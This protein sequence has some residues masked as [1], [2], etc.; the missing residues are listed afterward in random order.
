MI[1]GSGSIPFPSDFISIP[2]FHSIPFLPFHSSFLLPFHPSRPVHLFHSIILHSIHQTKTHFCVNSGLVCRSPD[3]CST[4]FPLALPDAR[5]F[6]GAC[7]YRGGQE[8]L[9]LSPNW[10]M[11]HRFRIDDV[12]TRVHQRRQ[13]AL[14]R[15]SAMTATRRAHPHY[16]TGPATPNFL[17]KVTKSGSASVLNETLIMPVR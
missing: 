10:F 15:Q 7:G 14:Q 12:M 5:R 9:I 3:Q 13:C 11:P 4:A 1:A 8:A 17:P 6:R 16:H 2:P